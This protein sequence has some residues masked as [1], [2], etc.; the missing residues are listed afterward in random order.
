MELLL[1]NGADVEAGDHSAA[2]PLMRAALSGSCSVIEGLSDAGASLAIKSSDT[3]HKALSLVDFED[4]TKAARII[5]EYEAAIPLSLGDN[6]V[7]SPS[8]TSS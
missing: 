1:S 5:K 7:H 2:T 8:T 6:D 4:H 3:R